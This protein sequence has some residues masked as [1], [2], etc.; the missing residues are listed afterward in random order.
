MATLIGQQRFLS[1]L[2]QQIASPHNLFNLLALCI[3]LLWPTVTTRELSYY[4]DKHALD[5]IQSMHANFSLRLLSYAAKNELAAVLSPLSLAITLSLG[6]AAAG[7]AT[8]TQINDLFAKGFNDHIVREYYSLLAN[9]LVL[10]SNSTTVVPGTLMVLHICDDITVNSAVLNFAHDYLAEV[11]Q[12]DCDSKS[13]S[14]AFVN[15]WIVN[16]TKS[17]YKV[18]SKNVYNVDWRMILVDCLYLNAAW[19][20]QFDEEKIVLKDFYINEHAVTQVEMLSMWAFDKFRY[21]EDVDVQVLGIPYERDSNLF[22]YIF[23]PRMKFTL[24]NIERELTG[25]RLLYLI[26]RSKT[27]DVEVEIPKFSIE[28]H[29]DLNLPLAGLGMVE[30]FTSRADFPAISIQRTHVSLII[31]KTQF[32]VNEK[33][34]FPV[35][36]SPA[37]LN[38]KLTTLWQGGHIKFI[39]N[40]P[41]MFV[42]VRNDQIVLIGHYSCS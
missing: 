37:T 36:S 24:R 38:D 1:T 21:T 42:V 34:S 22:F 9:K 11:Q 12:F 20:Y 2:I 40:H 35:N 28:N 39:A 14:T 4:L 3:L 41:F 6:S 25:R 26:A 8:R 29:F 16:Q 18:F 27:V 32:L 23:L 33:G 31:Q 13:S 15:Q 30:A 7:G 19:Q 17:E 10:E 5:T